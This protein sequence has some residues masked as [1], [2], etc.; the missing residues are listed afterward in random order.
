MVAS[1][2]NAKNIA[3]DGVHEPMLVIDPARPESR[4]CML[5]WLGLPD[6][7]KRRTLNIMNQ[8]IDPVYDGLVRLLPIQIVGHQEIEWV[9]SGHFR[10]VAACR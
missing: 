3:L 8:S 4:K 9:I 10:A 6:P 2:S 7:F 5:K 1:L